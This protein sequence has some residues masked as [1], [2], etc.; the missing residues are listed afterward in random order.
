MVAFSQKIKEKEQKIIDQTNLSL[1]EIQK[2][3]HEQRKQIELELEK[4]R[5]D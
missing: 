4:R 2:F 3:Y 1:A 5:K